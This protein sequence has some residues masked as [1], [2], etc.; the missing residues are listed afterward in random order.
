MFADYHLSTTKF[1]IDKHLSTL[2]KLSNESRCL[3]EVS[4]VPTGE[5]LVYC[6]KVDNIETSR[7]SYYHRIIISK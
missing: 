2:I 6:K 3:V 1:L 5:F 4:L 7:F